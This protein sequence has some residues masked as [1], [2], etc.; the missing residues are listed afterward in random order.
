MNMKTKI[1]IVL[2]VL[3]LLI[4]AGYPLFAAKPSVARKLSFDQALDMT[5][6]NSHV[7]KQVNYLREQKNQERL[8]AKGLFFP[9]IGITASAV[10][11]SD[12]ITLDLTP[13]KD[14]IT[15]LYKT[16]GSYGKFGDVPGL[17]DDVA[18][19]VIRQ[20]LNAGL[21]EIQ[22]EDWNHASKERSTVRLD[23]AGSCGGIT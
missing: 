22:N 7:M 21:G 14:A 11:M 3:P 6:Q 13:V 2:V 5:Y 17:P 23:F 12:P 4:S 19:Q 1:N 20:K 9:T 18:T 8:A 16:L 15:P 10:M